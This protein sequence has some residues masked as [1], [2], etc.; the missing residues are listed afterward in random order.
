[1]SSS[2][3]VVLG[4]NPASQ[5]PALLSPEARRHHLYILGRTGTGKSTLLL[6]LLAQDIEAGAGVALLDPHGDL[7]EQLLALIPS[8]RTNDVV[9]FDAADG[10]FPVAFNP[11]ETVPP[12]HPRFQLERDLVASE[13]V[14]VFKKLWADSWGPRLE[15]L[16]RN[17]ILALI[18]FPGY[19]LDKSLLGLSR[20]LSDEL[21]RTRII[22]HVR[23]PLVR[24]FWL[25]E[26]PRYPRQLQAEA[27][28]PVQN[29]VGQLLAS[30]FI[31]H[32]V[33]RPKSTI[34]PRDIMDTGKV[35]IFSLAKGKIG[36]DSAALLGAML[37]TKFALA[38]MARAD[39][40]E[41]E[42]RPF[43]LAVDE[44]QNYGTPAFA[45]ILSEA[46]KYRLSLT[47]AHQYI[48]QMLYRTRFPGHK[49]ALRGGA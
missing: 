39:V 42:R 18:E 7:A 38:A 40:P 41:T 28:S 6:S 14:T 49:F 8:R 20:F 4:I 19:Q 32:I 23:D 13:L 45:D 34:D 11:L 29:K 21:F 25:Q 10:D 37:V 31:R 26:F 44:F 30:T 46:R 24:Y 47:L 48:E 5:R 16:L 36:E 27:L 1:M 22:R 2:N 15:Y 43:H 3:H 33:A 35:A 9:L 12:G 17:A